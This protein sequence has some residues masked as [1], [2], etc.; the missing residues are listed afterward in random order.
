[1][2]W[3]WKTKEPATQEA[4]AIFQYCYENGLIL[5]KAGQHNNVIRFLGPLNMETAVAA[6]GLAVL[7]AALTVF[8]PQL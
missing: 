7:E 6:E 1:M 8:S 4:V 3:R 2:R 5:M